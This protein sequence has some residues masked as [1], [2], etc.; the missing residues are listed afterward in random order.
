MNSVKNFNSKT[1]NKQ[2][3]TSENNKQQGEVELQQG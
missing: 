2:Q 3:G 1:I